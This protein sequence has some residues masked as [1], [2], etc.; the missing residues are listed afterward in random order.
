MW[1]NPKIWETETGESEVQNCPQLPKF[2]ASLG[3]MKACLKSKKK[4]EKRLF[5]DL[6]LRM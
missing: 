4:R 3:Y 5:L 6:F 2:T 1:W